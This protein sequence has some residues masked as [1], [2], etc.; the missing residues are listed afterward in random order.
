MDNDEKDALRAWRGWQ[1]TL[2]E[3]A[4]VAAGLALLHLGGCSI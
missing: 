1:T 4:A 3:L 2:C